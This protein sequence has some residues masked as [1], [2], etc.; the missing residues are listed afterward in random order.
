MDVGGGVMAG[1]RDPSI[2]LIE[3]LYRLDTLRE[4]IRDDKRIRERF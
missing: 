4:V 2:P 1:S 3:Y